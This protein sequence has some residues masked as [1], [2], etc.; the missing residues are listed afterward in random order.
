MSQ[1]RSL[2]DFENVASLQ[3]R[4]PVPCYDEHFVGRGC[5][6]VQQ[7]YEMAIAGYAF[8]VVPDGF[9]VHQPHP[10]F[11]YEGK[12]DRGK[13]AKANYQQFNGNSRMR[14]NPGAEEGPLTGLY[15]CPVDKRHDGCLAWPNYVQMM[16]SIYG[17]KR[18][19]T[20]EEVKVIARA[21]NRAGGKS[22]LVPVKWK[23]FSWNIRN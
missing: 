4:T 2:T 14:K 10:N 19:P 18:N 9:L 8:S 16:G 15:S 5:D 13:A 11:D 3:Y 6:K 22:N 20:P 17:I 21:V 23:A 12:V 1:T 7:I